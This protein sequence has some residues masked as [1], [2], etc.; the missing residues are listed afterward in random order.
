MSLR[1][2]M[3]IFLNIAALMAAG[4]AGAAEVKL[5]RD[6]DVAGNTL[7][8]TYARDI[9]KASVSGGEAVRIT[10]FQG[11]EGNPHLSP[12]GRWVAFTGE[13]E[14]N[15]DV[16]VTS[17]DGGAPRRLTYH[18]MGDNVVGW[19]PDGRSVLFASGRNQAPRGWPQLF[20]VSA[21]GGMP[22]PLPMPRA[23]NGSYSEDGTSLVYRRADQWDPGWR[24]YRGGQNQPLVVVNLETLAE[25]DLPWDNSLDLE[26]HWQGD[27]IYYLSNQSEVNNVYR[28]SADGGRVEAVTEH[29]DFDVTGFA[30]DGDTLVYEYRGDLMR[31]SLTGGDS[32]PIRISLDADFPWNR[33]HW[34]DVSGDIES[35]NLSPTG[36]RAVFV[37]R[38]DVFTVPKE[39]GAVRNLT[40]SSGSRENNAAWSNDGQRIAW[41]SDAAGEYNLVIADQ[42]GAEEEVI[43]LAGTGYYSELLWSPDDRYLVFADQAQQLWLADRESGRARVIDNQ[44]IVNVEV[45]MTPSWSPDSAYLAYARQGDNFYRSLVVYSIEDEEPVALTEG[46]A[47]LRNPVWDAAGEMLYVAASTN[48]GPAAS[49]LDLTSVAFTPTFDLYYLP[50]NS[51]VASPLLPRSD[52]EAGSDDSS[53]EE[54]DD[55]ESEVTVNV[56]MNGAASRMLPIG[57]SGRISSLMAGKAG[58]IFFL[59]QQDDKQH[60]YKYS[61]EERE[62]T[63]LASD[64]AEFR[65]SADGAE[66][67]VRTGSQWR[68]FSSGGPMGDDAHTLDTSLRKLV[69]NAAE[70]R[71]IFREAWRL[72]RDFFYV[73]NLHGADWDAMY[74]AYEPLVQYVKHAAD[75][76]FLLD[77]L[78]AE[79]SIGHS[80]TGNGDL[81]DAGESHVGLL[82]ADIEAS[83]DGFRFGRI[84]RGE[85]WF[86][87][88]QAR[89]PLGLLGNAVRE[90][91]YLLAVNGRSLDAGANLY[92]AFRGTEGQQ[93]R[94][95]ISRDGRE[96]NASDVTVVPIGND[97]ALRQNAWVEDNRRRVDEASDGRL[98]YVWVPNTAE[99]GF[100]YF[101]RYYFAQS[102]RQGAI[103]DERFNHGGFIAEYIIDILRREHMGYFNN[104][105]APDRPMVAPSNAILGPKVMLINEM[106]GSGGDM[107]PWMFR[108]HDIGTLIGKRTWGGLVGIWGVPLLVD[109]TRMT[110]P[111]SGFYTREGEWAVENEGVAPDV[112]VEA[113]TADFANG[114]DTQL[115]RA[116]D[117]AMQQL[118]TDAPTLI[119]QPEDPIRVPGGSR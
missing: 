55:E 33:P 88:D 23:R 17:I 89:A 53:S 83:D 80:Y 5:L 35:A 77:N 49:W 27:S 59:K 117:I 19:S 97:G 109:G 40:D 73:R 86:P 96:R 46:L 74:E 112:D 103:I 44:P 48:Y 62:A 54:G 102:R 41:F 30:I 2:S 67:L 98:A 60:L 115:E 47:D 22:S 76:T 34:E 50:L 94:L 99:N 116:I 92:A 119:G 91:D 84:Y 113:S 10:S 70:W 66:L 85:S 36:Q 18:P 45:R 107:L 6:P 32:R 78:G 11:R 58:E 75:M 16:Y 111:R 9:W 21:E 108:F 61:F 56:E 71:Q 101:N 79:T 93:T 95:T 82:G 3:G 8:F 104:Q 25:R 100:E 114:R 31:Q 68:I 13:Y 12:D 38:G 72:Q 51:D 118:E 4:T 52:E 87:D 57:E 7:V 28:V 105:F 1:H 65:V 106:S 39:H 64:V 37:A 15:I 63:S 26:P 43:E 90:G 81:P 14:G 20:T 24:N 69:D 42:Y 110:A 29:D